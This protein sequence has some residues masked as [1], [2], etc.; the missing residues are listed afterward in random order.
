VT[1]VLPSLHEEGVTFLPGH[2]LPALLE[3][4]AGRNRTEGIRALFSPSVARAKAAGREVW[5]FGA[6][7]M[8]HG[9]LE[10]AQA[11]GLGVGGFVDS[12]SDLW[13]AAWKG[14][15]VLGFEEAYGRG[16]RAF[17]VACRMGGDAICQAL[18][19]LGEDSVFAPDG[20]E[21]TWSF[22]KGPVPPQSIVPFGFQCFNAREIRGFCTR[23]VPLAEVLLRKDGV[24]VG[25]ATVAQEPPGSLDR[26]EFRGILEGPAAPGPACTLEAE[27]RTEGGA[28]IRIIHAGQFPGVLSQ[29]EAAFDAGRDC[30]FNAPFPFGVSLALHL[31]RPGTYPRTATWDDATIAQAVADIRNLDAD[32]AP[33]APVHAYLGFLRS[34]ATRFHHIHRRFPRFNPGRAG[35]LF[36]MDALAGATSV[37]EILSIAHHLHVLSS[38]GLGGTLGEFGCYKGLSTCMLSLACRETGFRLAVFDSFQG[39]PGASLNG[40]CQPGEFQGSLQ[41]VRDRVAEFGTSD[42][43]TYHPGFFSE[44]LR[45]PPVFP[46]VIWADVDL[47]S[48]MEDVMGPLFTR[49][50]RVSCVFSHE[51][52]EASLRLEGP[53]E[54]QG[55]A[56]E[57]LAPVLGAFR[58]AG[59][60]VSLRNLAGFTAAFWE[61]GAGIP[62][63]PW[64]AIEALLPEPVV[65]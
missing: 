2:G 55:V 37:P 9:A 58:A 31:F 18:A 40:H 62:A 23:D 8:G 32:L 65:N 3:E 28:S 63:L 6:G 10:E 53:V 12:R 43:V 19:G 11:Q 59:R 52:S 49:L 48:S 1:R 51:L 29:D 4:A 64:A 20:R 14:F 36:A 42:G 60:P 7:E 38:Y 47:R 34:L 57:V 26:I 41:E 39:L 61:T 17:L 45:Q 56:E 24:D 50:P 27:L 25:R 16:A 13:G 30:P 44:S 35:D 15:P 21:T 33:V 46:S 5:I 54:F 22:E